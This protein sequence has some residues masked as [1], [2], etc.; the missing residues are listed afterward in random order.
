[1]STVIGA[2]FDQAVAAA[3]D[4]LPDRR[5]LKSGWIG[6]D[7]ALVDLAPRVHRST[8]RRGP[9][10]GDSASLALV[11]TDGVE[12][13]DIPAFGHLIKGMSRVEA[14]AE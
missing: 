11:T 13:G 10:M 4:A 6:D 9:G 14:P 3:Q 12:T 8:A 1:M 5:V 2:H 7:A